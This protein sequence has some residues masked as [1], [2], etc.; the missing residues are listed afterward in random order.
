[1]K[2]EKIAADRVYEKPY[3]PFPPKIRLS[4]S[5]GQRIKEPLTL[6]HL[7]SGQR[8]MYSIKNMACCITT[9]LYSANY[10]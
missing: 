4:Q 3:H 6:D 1:M 5:H 10:C 2:C 9:V 8:P 7:G